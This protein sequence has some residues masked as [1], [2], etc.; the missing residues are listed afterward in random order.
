MHC[1]T[2]IEPKWLPELAPAFFK[3]ANPN[4]VSKAK[5]RDRIEP[6]F[7]KFAADKDD[8][9]ISKQKKL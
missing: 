1:I 8:W 5:Q 6:L 7:D 3:V 4:K 9:R 2:A